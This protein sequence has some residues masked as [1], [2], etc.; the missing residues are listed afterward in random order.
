MGL[1]EMEK[2]LN[3]GDIRIGHRRVYDMKSL[4]NDFMDAG[5]EIVTSGGYWLKPESNM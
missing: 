5:L 3:E 4:K 1:L 2:Q